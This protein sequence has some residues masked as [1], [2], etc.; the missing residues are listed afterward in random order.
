MS[1]D[2]KYCH[3]FSCTTCKQLKATEQTAKY[4][5][6][7]NALNRAMAKAGV[8]CPIVIVPGFYQDAWADVGGYDVIA[9]DETTAKRAA[10]W[11][12]AWLEARGEKGWFGNV[13]GASADRNVEL[14]R[15]TTRDGLARSFVRTSCFMIGD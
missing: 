6:I 14:D 8:T 7:H 15:T 9:K 5:A 3:T 13:W 10:R 1:H 11:L 4:N 2:P 12:K